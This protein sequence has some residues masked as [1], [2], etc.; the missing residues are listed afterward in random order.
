M[1]LPA[2]VT[3]ISGYNEIITHQKNGWL[4]NPRDVLSLKTAMKTFIQISD[5]ELNSS[6]NIAQK[7]IHQK[8]DR[9]LYHQELLSFYR[10]MLDEKVV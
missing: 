3:D 2:I 6:K 10:R 1:A 9:K 8:F 5:N 4:V 7:N